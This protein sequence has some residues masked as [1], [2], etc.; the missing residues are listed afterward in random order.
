MNKKIP[1]A[2]PFAWIGLMLINFVAYQFYPI[3]IQIGSG[4]KILFITIFIV[5]FIYTLYILRSISNKFVTTKIFSLTRNPVYINMLL[6]FIVF[7]LIFGNLWVFATVVPLFY[8]YNF[9]IKIEEEDLK[10]RL[11][12]KYTN[13]LRKVRRWI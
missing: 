11:G 6:G 10:I 3:D 4:I 9:V 13:Y 2:P 12:N 1:I 7:G 5:L 8:Y